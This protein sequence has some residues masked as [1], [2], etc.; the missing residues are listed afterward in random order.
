MKVL[1]L[2]INSIKLLPRN[3]IPLS[4]I[5]FTEYIIIKKIHQCYIQ[6]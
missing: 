5:A 1:N 4:T 3:I 6:K 2:L